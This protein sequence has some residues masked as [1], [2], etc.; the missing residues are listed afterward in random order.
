MLKAEDNVSLGE[1]I[2]VIQVLTLCSVRKLCQG[3][4]TPAVNML[5]STISCFRYEVNPFMQIL[6][7]C[8]EESFVKESSCPTQQQLATHRTPIP[9][10]SLHT[11]DSMYIYIYI[12][13]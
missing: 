4:L 5:P 13:R 2:P 11:I 12:A 3:T 6:P 10:T 9:N 1:V 7:Q 8:S